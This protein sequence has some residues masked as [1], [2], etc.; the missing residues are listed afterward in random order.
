MKIQPR[1]LEQGWDNLPQY[2][3]KATDTNYTN[4]HAY[5]IPYKTDFMK[6]IKCKIQVMKPGDHAQVMKLWKEAE[7][8]NVTKSDDKKGVAKYLKK[9]PGLS[10]VAVN[11]KNKIIG[12]VLSGHD[13][14]R[15][16]INHLAVDKAYRGMGIGKALAERCLQKYKKLGMIKCTLFVFEDNDNARNFWQRIGWYIRTDLTMMQK[17]L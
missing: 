1:E 13:G 4:S 10:F 3:L 8:V 5:G 15:A 11:E 17:N 2:T 16:Y 7:G 12:A 6:D 9:N 14:R